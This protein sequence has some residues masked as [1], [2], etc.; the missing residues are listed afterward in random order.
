MAL[1][2]H[3]KCVQLELSL[4]AT[5]V[6]ICSVSSSQALNDE[7]EVCVWVY[8]EGEWVSLRLLTFQIPR[9]TDSFLPP[10]PWFFLCQ[11]REQI[12]WS[13]LQGLEPLSYFVGVTD[14]WGFLW[15]TELVYERNAGL[16]SDEWAWA[17]LDT[18]SAILCR[19]HRKFYKLN[20]KSLQKPHYCV[21]CVYFCCFILFFKVTSY[22]SASSLG[23]IRCFLQS[24]VSSRYLS[25]FFT[26][27]NKLNLLSICR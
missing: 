17:P 7:W 25:C 11:H 10:P 19:V 13:H 26:S 18:H 23:D 5:A 15:F 20:V 16:S 21:Y 6:V 4:I 2:S 22:Y 9:R 12:E 24:L 3:F 8:R 1:L 27:D 14:A